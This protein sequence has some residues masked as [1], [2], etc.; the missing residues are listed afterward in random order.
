MEDWDPFADPA[1][2]PEITVSV[3]EETDAKSIYDSRWED[4]GKNEAIMAALFA[5]SMDE[6][7]GDFVRV[8]S[9]VEE[10]HIK[11]ESPRSNTAGFVGEA[12]PPQSMPG[13]QSERRGR[14]Y[15]AWLRASQTPTL[16][17]T[18][19]E[20]VRGP[21]CGSLG[22]NLVTDAGSSTK[23]PKLGT[24]MDAHKNDSWIQTAKGA[25][26][27]A[28]AEENRIIC[29]VDPAE[30]LAWRDL[31]FKLG[32][33]EEK[34]SESA[35]KAADPHG[36]WGNQGSLARLLKRE[37][38]LNLSELPTASSSSTS[39]TSTMPQ[40]AP[41]LPSLGQRPSRFHPEASQPKPRSRRG[42]G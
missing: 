1:E 24:V 33:S 19:D 40:A 42:A 8:E 38:G 26:C 27:E 4:K 37:T 29:E 9:H 31:F 7:K 20:V 12:P 30:M 34:P 10:Q 36:T 14:G 39:S 23:D 22:T 18:K 21:Q 3:V 25:P 5:T 2:F 16:T 6:P 13:E 28:E 17:P 32:E 35:S 41:P 15:T 11:L